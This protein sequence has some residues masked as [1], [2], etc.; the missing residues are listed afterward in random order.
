MKNIYTIELYKKQ[1]KPCYVV[2]IQ[3]CMLSGVYFFNTLEDANTHIDNKKKVLEP[4]GTLH[5][6]EDGNK[7]AGYANV[8][9]TVL[10]CKNIHIGE[11]GQTVYA[12][13]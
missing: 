7:N 4:F 13:D 10:S 5:Y 1:N 8:I 9:K 6:D 2:T 12:H 11:N 3:H